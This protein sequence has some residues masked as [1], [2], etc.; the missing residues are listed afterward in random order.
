MSTEEPWT[1]D[2]AAQW[3][4]ST[5]DGL[6]DGGVDDAPVADGIDAELAA[7]WGDWVEPTGST[8]DHEAVAA[9]AP[10]TDEPALDESATDE[11]E[12]E[13]VEAPKDEPADTVSDGAVSDRAASGGAEFEASVSEATVSGAATGE[14]PPTDPAAGSRPEPEPARATVFEQTG[15]PA[16]DQALEALGGIDQ[17]PLAEHGTAYERAHQLLQ[18]ALSEVE[19]DQTPSGTA[20][21][22]G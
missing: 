18:E 4:S 1:N 12:A 15:E 13:G 7:R 16:V 10:A 8:G 21:Q 19:D 9:S 14:A 2:P 3:P 11:S 17:L 22:H 6:R 20:P 5:D